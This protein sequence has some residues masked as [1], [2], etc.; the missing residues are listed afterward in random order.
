[1]D[2]QTLG[3][4]APPPATLSSSPDQSSAAAAPAPSGSGAQT[5]ALIAFPSTGQD[6]ST[7]QKADSHGLPSFTLP[8]EVAKIFVGGASSSVQVSFKVEHSPNEIVT[9]FRDTESGEVISQ[10]PSEIMI[11]MAEFFD[12]V[13]GVVLDK[14][15]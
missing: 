1:M 15:A 12:Q 13:A 5:S 11:K 9:V 3:P 8:H 4:T 2:V 6:P 7:G 10:V 14:H